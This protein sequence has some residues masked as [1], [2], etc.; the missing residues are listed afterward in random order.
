MGSLLKRV[1]V[2][3]KDDELKPENFKNS[4]IYYKI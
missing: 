4:S 3:K 2:F 1:I